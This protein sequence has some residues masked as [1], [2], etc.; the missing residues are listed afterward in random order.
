M[1]VPNGGLTIRPRYIIYP[2]NCNHISTI[3]VE[4]DFR[5]LAALECQDGHSSVAKGILDLR[6]FLLEEIL[7]RL[8]IKSLPEI[9]Q[10]LGNASVDSLVACESFM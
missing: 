2:R 5:I 1:T 3:I 8:V 6:H 4:E 7:N 10:S 9:K